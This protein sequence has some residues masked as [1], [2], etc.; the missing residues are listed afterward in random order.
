M[1]AGNAAQFQST[2]TQIDAGGEFTLTYDIGNGCP[3]RAKAF[4]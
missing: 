2:A 1:N 3:L 4:R